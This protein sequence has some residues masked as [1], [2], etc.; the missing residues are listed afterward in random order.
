MKTILLK[1]TK[2]IVLFFSFACFVFLPMFGQTSL[3]GTITK[4][5]TLSLAKSPFVIP[6]S[7]TIQSGKTLTIE[8]GVT[9]KFGASS[10]LNINGTMNATNVIFTSSSV[11]P[12]PGSWGQIQTGDYSNSGTVNLTDCKI[13]Y[14]QK[15]VIYKGTATLINTDVTNS[16]YQAIHVEALGVL[17]MNGGLISTTNASAMTNYDGVNAASNSNV[18]LSGV[19]I[20]NYDNGLGL[21]TDANASIT[22]INITACNYPI[23]YHSVANL[24]VAGLNS[25]SGNNYVAVKMEFSYLNKSMTLP[26]ISIPYYFPSGFNI[27]A[28]GSLTVASKNILKFQ[29]GNSMNVEGSLIANAAVGEN[30]YFTSILDDNWGGDTNKDGTTTA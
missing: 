3:S 25:F 7:L 12:V 16:S 15:F 19:Y 26:F 8:S 2:R 5:S 17:N 9:V 4:D 28:A 11:T 1:F 21:N 20:Q 10:S 29:N 14:A 27:Q 24:T 23:N 30:I 22:N 13:N 6:S 18:T